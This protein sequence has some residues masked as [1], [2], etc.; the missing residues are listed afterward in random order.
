MQ[1]KGTPGRCDTLSD[2]LIFYGLPASQ[3][4]KLE[5]RLLKFEAAD[6]SALTGLMLR[7]SLQPNAAY[8]FIG[9]NPTGTAL[10]SSRAVTGGATVLLNLGP[11][12]YPLELRLDRQGT[13]LSV[14]LKRRQ[15]AWVSMPA[16]GLLLNGSG[17]VGHCLSS[18]SIEQPAGATYQ[19]NP[20]DILVKPTPQRSSPVRTEL[21][22]G[23]S[24]GLDAAGNPCAVPLTQAAE[25]SEAVSD[26][27]EQSLQQL[28][29]AD[30]P[31]TN[32]TPTQQ[33][34]PNNSGQVIY[35]N[36]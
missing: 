27:T 21:T 34:N 16:P 10:L 23:K 18:G 11:V 4:L 9:V 1:L 5:T 36:N 29:E 25:L 22:D 19:W 33:K 24:Y 28:L 26:Q 7:E 13:R 20:V 12:Q 35:E 32:P 2:A 31:T 30:S 15:G 3:S 8:L 14:S 6:A 17:L